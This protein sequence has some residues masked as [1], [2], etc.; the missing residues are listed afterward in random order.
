[1][2][3]SRLKCDR[4]PEKDGPLCYRQMGWIEEYMNQPEVK[5][6]KSDCGSSLD[7]PELTSNEID[8]G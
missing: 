4:A 5:K 7:W 6:R 2:Y 1:M 8:L 3:D